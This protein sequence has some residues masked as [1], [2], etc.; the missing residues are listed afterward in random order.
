LLPRHVRSIDV[1]AMRRSGSAISL[2]DTEEFFILTE[3]AEGHCHAEEFFKM[4]DDARLEPLD[5]ER[6]DALC[7]YLVEIHSVRGGEP[8]LYVRRIRELV[9]HSECIMGL[10]DSYPVGDTTVNRD[11][12]RRVEHSCI[13]WRWRLKDRVHRL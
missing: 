12:L 11:A 10:V 2:G 4:R 5:V 13:D 6:A 1:A 8:G 3:Y 9:G 7:D